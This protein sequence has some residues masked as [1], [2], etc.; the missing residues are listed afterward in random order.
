MIKT[1]GVPALVGILIAIGLHAWL[2]FNLSEQAA[3]TLYFI[4]VAVV[5]VLTL[6]VRRIGGSVREN[7]GDQKDG[8]V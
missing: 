5:E 7:G 8:E 4:C 6:V 2:G 1:F 3:F